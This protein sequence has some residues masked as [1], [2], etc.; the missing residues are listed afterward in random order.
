M[1]SSGEVSLDNLGSNSSF[2]LAVSTLRGS[3]FS[4]KPSTIGVLTVSDMQ[5]PKRGSR[6]FLSFL[7]SR[8]KIN[9]LSADAKSQSGTDVVLCGIIPRRHP[10]P[11]S[12]VGHGNVDHAIFRS[13]RPPC[14]HDCS[15]IETG[16][17]VTGE[18]RNSK[19]RFTK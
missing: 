11:R 13:P 18:T 16:D 4:F 7:R 2:D 9:I 5:E 15:P 19:K 17:D 12:P 14:G 8:F 3:K 10:R 6:G 1:K